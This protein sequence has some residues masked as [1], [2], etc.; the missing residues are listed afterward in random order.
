MTSAELILARVCA[1]LDALVRAGAPYHGLIPSVL[2]LQSGQLL[3]TLP[4]PIPGQ[5]M[6]DRSHPG[7]NLIHDQALL[8]TLLALAEALGRPDYGAA[9]GDYLRHW[10][11]HCTATVTGLF[12]WGEHAF[13][14]LRENRV[15]NSY[16]LRAPARPGGAPG[17]THDHLRQAPLWL[18]Q[19]LTQYPPQCVER[20]GEGLDFHWKEGEPP[21][22][23]RHAAIEAPVRPPRDRRSFDFPRHSGFYIFDWSFAY[24]QTGRAEFLHQATQMADYWWLKRDHCGLL[25]IESRSPASDVHFFNANAP[26]Q[27]I[28]LAASLLEAAGLLQPARPDLAG[29]WRER[30]AVYLDGFFAAP[31][32]LDRG[33]F[34]LLCDRTTNEAREVMPVWGS[35]YGVWPAAYVALTALCAYRLTRDHRLLSWAA[36]VGRRYDGEPLPPGVAVPAMDA[37][38]GLELLADLYDLTGDRR[39]LDAALHLAGT[40][41]AVYLDTRLP[42]GAAGIGWYES[43][44][45]PAFLLHGLARTALLSLDRDHCPLAPDY[46]TR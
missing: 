19:A 16:L 10:A 17:A 25:L 2:D 38:L 6:E 29:V 46:T 23:S 14:H 33:V 27:T 31:H 35:R 37:G 41:L 7:C 5:R 18:W 12:P 45:G 43:Q 11:T 40:L 3:E 32:D 15:G 30:A 24:L 42:R 26:G 21:E 44:M 28:S 8:A 4:A 1:A 20:F 39:W 34:V 9:A 13:W 22:Y 36:A